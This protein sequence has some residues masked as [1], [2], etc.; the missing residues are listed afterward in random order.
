MR[1]LVSAYACEPGRGSEPGVGWNWAREL[2]AEHEVWVLTRANNRERIEAELQRRPHPP[3]RFLYVD[4][5]QWIRRWK[6]GQRGIHLYAYGWQVAARRVAR[7]AHRRHRFELVHHI[8]FASAFTPALTWLPGVPF[9]WGPVG[10]GVRVPWRL[11]VGSG[12]RAVAYETLRSLRR[13][14]ARSFD[15][16]LRMT[17]RRAD[18]ILVQNPETMAWLPRPYRERALIAPN[19]GVD[20][21]EIASRHPRAGHDGLVA[22]AAGRLIHVKAFSLAV[23]ALAGVVDLPVRLLVAGEGPERM[24]LERLAQR[25][26][27]SDRVTFLGML[28]REAF[29]DRLADSDVLLFPSLHDECPLVVVEAMSQGTV[30]I[31]LDVGGPA[32]L[33]GSIGY[34]VPAGGRS[35]HEVVAELADAIR[36]AWG[37][38]DLPRRR[39]AAFDLA[40]SLSW[41]R[42]L[43]VLEPFLSESSPTRSAVTS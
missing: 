31:V 40:R 15:P 25:L 11:V 18:L 12:P 20:A 35:P 24:R 38:D 34:V 2:A 39:A 1:V 27:V 30:P 7:D 23:R 3:M 10:G 16:L 17:W 43:A 9:V 5:P 33:V 8:T 29:L 4:L 22:M 32:T 19:A 6:R 37:S 26:G 14:L 21:R 41:S 36:D 28:P 42:K 13:V